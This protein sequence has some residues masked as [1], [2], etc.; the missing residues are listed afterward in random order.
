MEY[1]S[2]AELW[3]GLFFSQRRSNFMQFSGLLSA[4]ENEKSF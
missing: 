1:R 2:E 3:L 4:E